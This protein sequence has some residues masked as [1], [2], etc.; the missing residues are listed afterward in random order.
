MGRVVVLLLSLLAGVAADGTGQQQVFQG[1]AP[2]GGG[3]KGT[4]L[5]WVNMTY[6]TDVTACSQVIMEDATGES[7]LGA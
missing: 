6:P 7:A 5:Y 3:G 4:T 1:L 2:A